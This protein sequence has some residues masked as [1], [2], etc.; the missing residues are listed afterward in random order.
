IGYAA[1]AL[2][3]RRFCVVGGLDSP[4]S[5]KPS[6][7]VWSLDVAAA[8]AVW[9]REPDLPGPGVFVA[10]AASDGNRLYAF[11]GIGFDADGKAIPAKT[12]YRLTP[13][14]EKWEQLADLPE[15]RVGIAAP[16][17]LV[18]EH[19]FFLIGGYA[20]VFPGAPRE[21][22]GFSAQTYFYDF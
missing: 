18:T 13:G 8:S 16:C 12:A 14:A 20:E 19:E 6:N 1:G 22:P 15:P 11:G 17:P 2:V 7:E 21:H 9:R 4:T 10:A 3:G 5:K